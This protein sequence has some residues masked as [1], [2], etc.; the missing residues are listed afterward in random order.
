LSSVPAW[1]G[2]RGGDRRRRTLARCRSFLAVAILVSLT[3]APRA[4]TESE[5]QLGFTNKLDYRRLD[6]EDLTEEAL[7]NRGE[8][9]AHRGVFGAWIRLESLQISDA[10]SYDPFG[11]GDDEFPGE[12]RIDRTELTKRAFT[13]DTERVRATIGDFSYA[14][15]RGLMLTVFEDE[16]L[17]FDS[18]LEGLLARFHH[19][20]GSVTALGG[21]KDENRFR[22]VF[23]EPERFGPLRVGAGFVEAWGGGQETN[24]LDRERHVGGLLELAWGPATLYGELTGRDFPGRNGRGEDDESGHG[25]FAQAIVSAKGITVSGEARDF[26]K[27][28][29]DFNNPP[30]TLRQQAWTLLNRVHGTVIADIPNRDVNGYLVEVEYAH[31]YFTTFHGS[32]SWLDQDDE[33]NEFRSLYGEARTTWQERI[34]LTGAAA[35]SEFE[36]GSVFE[37]RI[38]GFSEVVYE[39]DDR[40]SLTGAIEWNEVTRSD[41]ATQAFEFPAEFRERIFSLSW[42]R[43]P[44]LSATVTYEDSTDPDTVEPRDDWVTVLT[45]IAVS[46]NHN[47]T[48]SLGSERGG[49]KCSGGVC[50]FEPAFEGLKVNWIARY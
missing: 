26:F 20:R 27:F 4:Q 40:N 39:L 28:E 22:A 3:S 2:V 10:T 36:F 34:S 11:E 18:Q 44:W 42:G 9:T 8:L 35:E 38:G 5:L 49:W 25:A 21:S 46:E 45:E 50:F 19:E 6:Q 29:H 33:P 41:A 15:G 14:F 17:N 13:L 43:S 24:I 12:Q 37:E 32:A 23:V 47:L 16:A 30:T 48:L 31:D 7:R 1:R